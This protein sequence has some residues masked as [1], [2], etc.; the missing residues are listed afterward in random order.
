MWLGPAL[1]IA[2]NIL[3][4][5]Y[6]GAVFVPEVLARSVF[7]FLPAL[8]ELKTVILI[9]MAVLYFGAYFAFAVFWEKIKPYMRNVFFAAIGL[10][11]VN[12]LMIFPLVGRG[13]LGYKFPQGWMSASLPLLL[14][15]WMFARGLQFQDR[16]S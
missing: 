5:R 6:L 14:S 16:R 3:L 1:F 15:H 13:I 4:W 10:W 9:N 12:I 2:V 8:A 11:L 7:R